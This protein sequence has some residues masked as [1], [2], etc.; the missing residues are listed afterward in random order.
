MNNSSLTMD[1]TKTN[2]YYYLAI[3]NYDRENNKAPVPLSFTDTRNQSILDDASKY[4][5]A[6]QKLYIETANIPLFVPVVR[7]P[8]VN[9][10]ELVYSFTMSKG[11][12]EY[13]RY[14]QFISQNPSSQ[15]PTLSPTQ[16][17]TSDY[18]YIYHIQYWTKLLNNTLSECWTGLN[19]VLVTAGQPAIT[20]AK[21]RLE[22]N[23]ENS[24]YV[25][26]AD[27]NTFDEEGVNPI[28]LYMNNNMNHILCNFQTENLGY[29]DKVNGKNF[30]FQIYNTGFN[31]YLAPPT[32]YLQIYQEVSSVALFSSCGGLV[33]STSILP[34]RGS[35]TGQEKDF[36]SDAFTSSNNNS[37]SINVL[38][39]FTI[40]SNEISDLYRP[41]ILYNPNPSYKWIDLLSSTS[42]NSININVYWRDNFGRLNQLYLPSGATSQLTL[43]F[44]N[45]NT[46]ALI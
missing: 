13:Q 1:D 44:R 29:V 46:P 33:L 3:T 27:S 30:R 20:G 39:D 34:I 23:I 35:F 5:V 8:N 19:N 16:Q 14:I 10:N 21:P 32:T 24:K 9:I 36:G 41:F 37:N 25:L 2:L 6:V 12:Y 40:A 4:R 11:I 26:F 22:F 15:I 45:K 43:I 17:L 38:T 18:Y 7:Q 28:K 31:S 42:I